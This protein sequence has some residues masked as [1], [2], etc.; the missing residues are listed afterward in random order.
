MWMCAYGPWIL[1]SWISKELLKWRSAALYGFMCQPCFSLLFGW[2]ADQEG[3]TWCEGRSHTPWKH[4]TQVPYC[5][6]YKG[7]NRGL[8]VCILLVLRLVC[9]DFGQTVIYFLQQLMQSVGSHGSL[10]LLFMKL[11]VLDV[12]EQFS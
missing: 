2:C 1:L 10:S 12:C 5:R 6:P 7:G 8:A 11:M 9:P 4:A 3:I